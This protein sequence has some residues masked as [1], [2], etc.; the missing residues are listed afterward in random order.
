MS[1]SLINDCLFVNNTHVEFKYPVDKVLSI[2]QTMVVL[3]K[4][5]L[6]EVFN[7]NIFG[8]NDQGKIIWQ[9]QERLNLHRNDEPYMNIWVTDDDRLNCNDSIGLNFWIDSSNGSITYVG[10]T[11]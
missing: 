11:K 8:V 9:V 5:P 6:T 3:L 10:L 4:V 7:E 2:N 1:Y